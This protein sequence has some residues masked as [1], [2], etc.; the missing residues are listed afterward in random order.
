MNIYVINLDR[1]PER[2]GRLHALL[3]GQGATVKRVR[4]VDGARLRERGRPARRRRGAL[5]AGNI[6]LSRFEIAIATSHRIAWRKFLASGAPM[7]AVL[8]DDAVL[9]ADFAAFLARSSAAMGAFDWVKLETFPNWKVIV[10]PSAA[11]P[12]LGRRICRLR[13]THMGAAGYVVTRAGA[14][15][16]MALSAG[17]PLGA[18][19][20]L[21][22]IERLRFVRPAL[23]IGQ[24]VPAPVAQADTLGGDKGALTSYV[25]SRRGAR[26]GFAPLTPSKIWKE[27]VR[28]IRAARLERLGAVVPFA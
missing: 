3:A 2:Y 8:E 11:P 27:I 22:D 23:R 24:V 4:A 16:L 15:R 18:D 19:T 9:G 14:M 5:S 13:S 12:I 20:I 21:F 7:C 1:H 17:A 26:S 10:E 25:G 6:A 28:P